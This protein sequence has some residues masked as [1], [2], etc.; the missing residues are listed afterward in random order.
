MKFANVGSIR[1]GVRTAEW[2]RIFVVRVVYTIYVLSLIEGPLRKWILPDF[3]S[4]ITFLR[5]PLALFIYLYAARFGFLKIRGVAAFWLCFAGF[6]CL[7]GLVQFMGNGFGFVG[8]ALGVRAYWL[9][10]PLAFVVANSFQRDD[11]YNFMRMNLAVAIPYAILVAF[12]YNSGMLAFINRGVG[13]DAPIGVSLGGDIIRPFGLFTY[14]S[15]NAQFASAMIAVLLAAHLGKIKKI[16]SSMIVSSS[17]AIAAMAVL[18]GSRVIFFDVAV[19]F[20]LTALGVM[21]TQ[22]NRYAFRKILGIVIFFGISA[23]LSLYAFPDMHLAMEKRIEHAERAEGSISQR[24]YY[25]GF[26]FIDALP[27]APLTGYGIG[28][29]SS[30]VSNFLGV[31][32]FVHGEGDTQRNVNELGLVL[33]LFLI[34]GRWLTAAW[35]V[36]RAFQC[37]RFVDPAVWPFVG[38]VFLPLSFGTITNSPIISFLVWLFMGFALVLLRLDSG[39]FGQRGSA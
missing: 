37:S 32:Q 18:T 6:T 30:G 22:S 31:P 4:V 8:W 16:S 3:N 25:S 39:D 1:S 7:F 38:F 2:R 29:G 9:Y 13:G 28:V 24:V 33:G 21:F 12:Q 10:L 17:I 34:A 11:L 5:D 27:D 20:I 35:L 36:A 15:P 19:I 23:G 14:A 26:S